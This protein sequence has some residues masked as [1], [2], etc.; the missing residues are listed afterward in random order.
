MHSGCK[1][2]VDSP[3]DRSETLQWIEVNQWISRSVDQQISGSRD[4]DMISELVC[5]HQWTGHAQGRLQDVL[6]SD[7]RWDVAVCGDTGGIKMI[8]SRI[9]GIPNLGFT[10]YSWT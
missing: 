9:E 4:Q 8:D 1:Y 3:M 2:T 5:K 7:H 6:G 10:S